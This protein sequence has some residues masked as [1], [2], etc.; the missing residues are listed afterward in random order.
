MIRY[1]PK[2]RAILNFI[3]EYG[4]ITSRICAKLFYKEDKFALDVARRV[5]TRLVNNKDIVSNKNSYGKEIIYQFKKNTVSDHKYYL[6]NFYA[7]INKLV[8]K[9]E[10]FKLEESWFISNKRSDAHIIFNNIVDGN[11]SFKSYLVEFDKYHKTNP[12]EK[13]DLIYDSGE[14]QEWYKLRYGLNNYFPDVVIINYSGKCNNE[15]ERD[16]KII[17]IDYD[18]TS[19]LQ[20]VILS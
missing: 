20:K 13:Y 19:L 18:F 7:E 4:F 17:G 1:T 15:T 10:Y 3:E 16:Y 14:V 2:I 12:I 8:T 9:V 6:L 5:L 11:D